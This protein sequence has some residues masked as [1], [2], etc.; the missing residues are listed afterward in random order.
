MSSDN[1]TPYSN[2][3]TNR[4][5]VETTNSA[6]ADAACWNSYEQELNQLVK[7]AKSGKLE[8]AQGKLVRRVADML[9]ASSESATP[10]A[11]L[12]VEIDNES[13][14]LATVLNIRG[15]ET[16]GFLYELANALT[17]CSVSIEQVIIRTERHRAWDTLLVT[18][19]RMGEKIKN[20]QRLEELRTAIVLIKHFT[21]LLP[22][23]PNPQA[24]LVHF[25]SFLRDLSHRPDWLDQLSTLDRPDVLAALAQLLGVSDF[26]WEDFLRLQYA[27]LFPVLQDI[28]R[29]KHRVDR[30]EL[31]ESLEA[32]LM[33]E[34]TLDRQR[35]ILNEFKDRELFRIN[36]RHIL[37]Y[38]GGIEPFGY[39]MTELAEVVIS[40]AA[41]FCYAD[42][43]LRFG[44]PRLLNGLTCPWVICG[45]GKCGGRELGSAS[46]LEL[47]F[48]YDSDSSFDNTSDEIEANSVSMKSSKISEPPEIQESFDCSS[49]F[50]KFVESV[51]QSI[52]SRSEGVFRIDLRLRPY[53]RAG[54]LAVSI[55]AFR[56]YFQ[57]DGPA[58]PYERQSLVKLRPIA[59]DLSLGKRISAIRD[60]IVYSGLPVDFSSIS[61][62]RE[63]QLRQRVGTTEFNAKL[64]R[65]GLVDIEY[66]IQ[67][68]QIQHGHR[69]PEVR[70]ENTRTA[71]EALA[72]LGMIEKADQRQLDEAYDFLRRLIDSLRMVHGDARALN[73]PQVS[74]PDFK[75]L[76][77]R[78]GYQ[79]RSSLLE[80]DLTRHTQAVIDIVRSYSATS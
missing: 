21:H 58:W 69:H 35:Q 29:L 54:S 43:Q 8:E 59:G 18:D 42:L 63:R 55:D 64:S 13:H 68:L 67:A 28:E 36:M 26:L 2:H 57:A 39:E 76:A 27:N 77:N 80:S 38:C 73:V 34:T 51:C 48:I 33:V 44:H 47:M 49:F 3:D 79:D 1:T 50:S 65:G 16:M 52:V 7:L 72:R 66:L 40:A 32:K 75:S 56:N 12:D 10:L 60:E 4:S 37:G 74:S 70:S 17:L 24:A 30:D 15:D 78:L 31:N 45:L 61:A 62:M 11:P 46:D 53:G 23:S 71:L 14:D 19:E 22:A 5:A 9:K 25:R 20:P 41:R 6:A